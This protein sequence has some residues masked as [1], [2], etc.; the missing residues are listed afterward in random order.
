MK[1]YQFN[2]FNKFNK[3]NKY[4]KNNKNNKNRDVKKFYTIFLLKHMVVFTKG[5]LN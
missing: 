5:P 4:N 1:G 3:Y 2:K